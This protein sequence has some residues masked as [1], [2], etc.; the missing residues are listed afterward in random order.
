[1]VAQ[2][3]A[4]IK[5]IIKIIDKEVIDYKCILCGDKEEQRE[6]P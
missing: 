6:R 3:Q 1:M 4:N 2:E 5:Q